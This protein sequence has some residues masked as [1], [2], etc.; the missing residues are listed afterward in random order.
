MTVHEEIFS[1]VRR[2]SIFDYVCLAMSCADAP[3][4]EPRPT[5]SGSETIGPRILL[6]EDNPLNRKVALR[7]LQKLGYKAD[8]VAD[9]REVIEALKQARYDIILMDCGMPELDGYETTRH[10]RREYPHPIRIIAL[11]AHSLSTDRDK[12]L[13]AGMDDY[14]TKPVS[15]EALK[16]AIERWRP[17]T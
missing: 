4:P 2:L 3:G 1:R 13:A 6:A 9:G 7:Q 17:E 8:A 12:C 15:L 11:T 5:V 16:A 14:L 10:L